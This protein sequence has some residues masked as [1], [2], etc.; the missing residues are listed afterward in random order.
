MS[1]VSSAP[2]PI[3][4]GF[5][6]AAGTASTSLAL[7]TL[8]Q[9]P[10]LS[11]SLPFAAAAAAAAAASL[12]CSNGVQCASKT[13]MSDRIRRRALQESAVDAQRAAKNEAAIAFLSSS[14]FA[15]CPAAP[16][17]PP[18][19][20]TFPPLLANPDL[21]SHGELRRILA[22]TP[23]EAGKLVYCI[24]WRPYDVDAA[25][26]L[27]WAKLAAL[28]YNRA[29]VNDYHHLR[30]LD[31]PPWPPR[32]PPKSSAS[33]GVREIKRALAER[34]A[35]LLRH[36]LSPEDAAARLQAERWRMRD[37]WQR[38]GRGWG[39]A[40]EVV[41]KRRNQWLEAAHH[42]SP[43]TTRSG[44]ASASTPISRQPSEPLLSHRHRRRGHP[45]ALGAGGSIPRKRFN[46]Q[47]E[48]EWR[49]HFAGT[50]AGNS[51]PRVASN[52]S[53]VVSAIQKD[54]TER[55]PGGASSG[56]S[57]VAAA[58]AAAAAAAST[59]GPSVTESTRPRPSSALGTEILYG[60]FGK[61]TRGRSQQVIARK[62]GPAP[63]QSGS[64]QVM[65]C[66]APRTEG[67]AA[68]SIKTVDP[69]SLHSAPPKTLTLTEG[70][71]PHRHRQQ[72][73]GEVDFIPW[74]RGLCPAGGNFR[75]LSI[76]PFVCHPWSARSSNPSPCT[77]TLPP[78]P[79]HSPPSSF[80]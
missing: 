79:P 59:A 54:G 22:H 8:Q 33:L 30:G 41:Q 66:D 35:F 37:E 58:A 74:L 77:A 38:A 32:K 48:L 13:T 1:P 14:N 76:Q 28:P 51:D 64:G 27:W 11:R 9:R 75:S 70:E 47:D 56:S 69:V 42:H 44:S 6:P 39:S 25:A 34:K 12:P 55:P 15:G 71:C 19:P 60:V 2:G 49:E 72:A 43:P 80:A 26:I 46:A 24:E 57:P 20:A 62:A 17:P 23:S 61:L 63:S 5:Q 36:G 3:I 78:Q 52:L 45:R 10:L 7:S 16:L 18:P 50:T 65:Q 73:Q 67:G 31:P 4:T 29:L 21:L 68:T 53:R 40:R